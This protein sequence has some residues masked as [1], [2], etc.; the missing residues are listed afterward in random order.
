MENET[1]GRYFHKFI[2]FSIPP[3]Y[4][5][6]TEFKCFILKY[7]PDCKNANYLNTY[8]SIFYV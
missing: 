2:S 1:S 8:N 7:F 5:V 4:I 3:Q 6:G